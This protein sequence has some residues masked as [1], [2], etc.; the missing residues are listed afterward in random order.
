MGDEVEVETKPTKA[1]VG[2]IGTF[3][4]GLMVAAP[5][6]WT[7]QEIVLSVLGAVVAA[8]AVYGFK[9]NPK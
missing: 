8:A 3:A 4:T 7:Q 5:D 9:N 2:F 1:I 6:G